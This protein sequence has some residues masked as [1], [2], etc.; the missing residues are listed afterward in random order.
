[1]P[2]LPSLKNTLFLNSKTCRSLVPAWQ[3]LRSLHLS[4]SAL[5][6]VA[7]QPQPAQVGDVREDFKLNF[8]GLKELQ[9]LSVYASPDAALD[10]EHFNMVSRLFVLVLP[11]TRGRAE[12]LLAGG[13]WS[14]GG[15]QRPPHAVR[16]GSTHDDGDGR[17]YRWEDV[18]TTVLC[19]AALRCVR[20][21]A[22]AVCRNVVLC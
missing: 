2:A 13:R 22:C 12:R 11:K 19:C 6:D 5:P 14:G 4:Y 18:L 15:R 10:Q 16:A 20:C 17:R 9:H 1:M 3:Q 7:D 21:A 8:G